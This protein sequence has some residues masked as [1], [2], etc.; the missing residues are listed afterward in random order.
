MSEFSSFAPYLRDPLV[1]IGFFLFL[2][3]LFARYLLQRGIIPP[4]PPTQ[5]FR[6]LKILLLYGFIIGLTL[7]LLGFFFKYKELQATQQQ[8]AATLSEQRAAREAEEAR[9]AQERADKIAA[10]QKQ[11]EDERRQQQNTLG[12]LK[13]ELGGNLKVANELRKNTETL[14]AL[15]AQTATL[16]RRPGIEIFAVLFP[17]ENISGKATTPP[18]ELSRRALESLQQRGLDSNALEQQKFASAASL[19]AATVDR[20]VPAM[21][22]LRDR[23]RTRYVPKSE[24]WDNNQDILRKMFEQVTPFQT[25]YSN[26]RSLRANYDIVGDRVIEYQSA[27]RDF[28]RPQDNRVTVES[29][30]RLLSTERLALSV[31]S[32]YG[33]DLVTNIAA[34]RDLSRHADQQ[35]RDDKHTLNQQ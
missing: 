31:G 10:Q 8:A 28:L 6:I 19:I 34:L 14:L 4:L 17:A 27:V 3:F 13:T 1:L 11:E 29:L 20:T 26:L 23:A 24:I 5:G 2:S 18:A 9:L 16:L 12:L 25:A 30:T 15:F 32:A 21:E 35:P 22:S 7:I 33:E